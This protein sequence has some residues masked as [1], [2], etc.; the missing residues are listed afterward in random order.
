M[1]TDAL[2]AISISSPCLSILLNVRLMPPFQDD[3]SICIGS[4]VLL[5]IMLAKIGE[6]LPSVIS[7]V[8]VNESFFIRFPLGFKLSLSL[9]CDGCVFQWFYV[10]HGPVIMKGAM[11]Q[12]RERGALPRSINE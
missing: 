4:S 12:K 3:H 9:S 5:L 2:G 8:S 1:A 7:A 10:N 11:A 6:E